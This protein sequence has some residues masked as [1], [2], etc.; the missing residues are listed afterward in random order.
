M[1]LNALFF[2]NQIFH[3]LNIDNGLYHTYNHNKEFCQTLAQYAEI[4]ES[5]YVPGYA[6]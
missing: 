3:I 6:C 4:T 5:G 1:L 2:Y